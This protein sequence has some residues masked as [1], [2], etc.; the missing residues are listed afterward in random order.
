MRLICMLLIMICVCAMPDGSQ[1]SSSV[2]TCSKQ[3]VSTVCVKQI[4]ARVRSPASKQSETLQI[5]NCQQTN[6]PA[7]TSCCVT[8]V[9]A[10]VT[11]AD[12]KVLRQAAGT[13]PASLR[14]AIKNFLARY[15]ELAPSGCS[16]PACFASPVAGVSLLK[17]GRCRTA[18][19]CSKYVSIR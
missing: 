7:L 16:D 4:D 8:Q 15:D 3:N 18:R 17:C 9:Y 5:T 13:T 11:P 6:V 2:R 19:Y 12:L 10:L 1:S 14:S